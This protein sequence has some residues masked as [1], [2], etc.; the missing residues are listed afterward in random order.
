MAEARKA[1]RGSVAPVF[2]VAC[3][4]LGGT[5]SYADAGYSGL[6]GREAGEI[7]GRTPFEFILAADFEENRKRLPAIISAR[8][9]CSFSKRY[10]QPDGTIVPVRA[11]AFLLYDGA[12]EKLGIFGILYEEDEHGRPA[13]GGAPLT[14]DALLWLERRARDHT[15]DGAVPIA[16]LRKLV[17]EAFGMPDGT[18][19]TA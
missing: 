1:G 17:I 8:E 3:F 5:I 10:V 18:E 6:L 16:R 9:P 15:R 14:I 4:D 11:H 12:G 2:G 7:I 19:H 13:C